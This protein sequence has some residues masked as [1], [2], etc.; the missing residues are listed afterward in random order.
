[1]KRP[2]R[3][4]GSLPP[5]GRV[6]TGRRT[7]GT[8]VP[9]AG[10]A[11]LLSLVGP[12]FAEDDAQALVRLR[13][14]MDAL[15]GHN[16]TCGNVVHCRVLALGYDDCGNP[17]GYLAFNNLRGIR[18]ELEGKIAEYTFIEEEQHRGKPKPTACKPAITPK[19]AC[20]NHRCT[21]GEASY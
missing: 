8:D 14:E 13:G 9:V 2:P 10:L 21:L 5:A 17:T 11:V 20:V 1:M 16:R 19:L 6:S 18:G 3:S 12:S 15:I 7:G 4:L